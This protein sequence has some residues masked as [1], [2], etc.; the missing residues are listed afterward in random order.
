MATLGYGF[1]PTTAGRA[2]I[3]KCGAE[4]K[5]LNLCRVSVGSGLIGLGDNMADQLELVQYVTDA[6]LGE[7]RHEDDRLYLT[8]QYDNSKHQEQETFYLSEFM[9]YGRDPD[10][11]AEVPVAYATLGDYR[12][13]VP[14][15]NPDYP[16]CI[17]SFPMV[18]V[19]SDDIKVVVSADPGVVTYNDLQ[20]MLNEGVI[21]F[22]K[23]AIRIPTGGWTETTDETI[24]ESYP[25]QVDIKDNVIK[26][27]MNPNLTVYPA[28]LD[29]ASDLCPVAQTLNGAL[30]LFAAKAPPRELKASLLL[31]GGTG[32]ID[33]LLDVSGDEFIT[34]DIFNAYRNKVAEDLAGK[35]DKVDDAAEGNLASFGADGALDDSDAG[36]SDLTEED[37]RNLFT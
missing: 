13:P 7:R 23:L 31:A 9:I 2:L 10:T 1:K 20:N 25:L 37:I 35:I 36:I 22:T 4:E 8:V 3:A 24:R 18:L 32:A 28:D 5:A 33:T 19:I 6:E 21:G 14:K 11:Q 17:F 34:G 30:R 16:A 29:D 27:H 26:A 12:Q 15:Y